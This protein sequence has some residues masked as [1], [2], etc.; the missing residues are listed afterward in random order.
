MVLGR[1]ESCSMIQQGTGEA[2]PWA[3]AQG[4]L[5]H[6]ASFPL[7]AVSSCGSISPA[8]THA[9]PKGHRGVGGKSTAPPLISRGRQGEACRESGMQLL[10][11]LLTSPPRSLV[12]MLGNTRD[13]NKSSCLHSFLPSFR[14]QKPALDIFLYK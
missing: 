10:L 9:C 1:A 14:I 8:C 4:A 2:H 3:S 5:G 6:Q 13:R 7:C 12:Q 11:A